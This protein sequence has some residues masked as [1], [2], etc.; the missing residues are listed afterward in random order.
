VGTTVRVP[1]PL[2]GLLLDLTVVPTPAPMLEAGCSLLS[3]PTPRAGSGGLGIL[4]GEV[5]EEGPH[6]PGDTNGAEYPVRL[7]QK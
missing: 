7:I 5:K 6:G 1:R 2:R 3:V 4:R